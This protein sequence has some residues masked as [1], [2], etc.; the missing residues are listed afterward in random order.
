MLLVPDTAVSIINPA[1]LDLGYDTILCTNQSF[2]YTL[3]AQPGFFHYLWSNGDTGSTSIVTEPGIYWCS[4][5]FGC[6]WF[7]DTIRVTA[8]SSF[9]HFLP[10]DTALCPSQY[11]FIISAPGYFPNYLWNTG[12]TT[13]SITVTQPATYWMQTTTPCGTH[14]DS[15]VINTTGSFFSG[16]PDLLLCEGKTDTAFAPP[17]FLS[18]QWS[19]GSADSILQIMEAGIYIL[20]VTDVC[21]LSH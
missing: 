12:D 1:I 10:A 5:D 13:N 2:P 19:T 21:G 20:N 18:Y 8:D 14:R 4:V 15:M 17:G 3:T 9:N 11:P 7:T 6:N 16:M